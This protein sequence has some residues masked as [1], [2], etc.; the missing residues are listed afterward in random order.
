[1]LDKRIFV[2]RHDASLITFSP[3]CRERTSK[4]DEPAP[5][6]TLRFEFFPIATTSPRSGGGR[7]GGREISREGDGSTRSILPAAAVATPRIRKAAVLADRSPSRPRPSSSRV[8]AP[9]RVN[10]TTRARSESGRQ[11]RQPHVKRDHKRPLMLTP[12]KYQTSLMKQGPT[13]TAGTC[14][15]LFPGIRWGFSRCAAL[16][17]RRASLIAALRR[18]DARPLVAV[19]PAIGG[20][21]PSI[22]LHLPYTPIGRNEN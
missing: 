9:N 2:Q 16:P 17:G 1:M 19:R 6:S 12:P 3:S 4:Y 11:S 5:E 21:A 22:A 15:G 10:N 14:H 8:A 18:G 20:C 13:G 7:P